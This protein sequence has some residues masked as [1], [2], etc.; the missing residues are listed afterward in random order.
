MRERCVSLEKEK[1]NI[2]DETYKILGQRLLDEFDSKK[3]VEWAVDVIKMGYDSIGRTHTG[4]ITSTIGYHVIPVC[5][6]TAA[7][8]QE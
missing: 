1:M 6:M 4:H 2:Q 7:I 5:I 8:G 3:M